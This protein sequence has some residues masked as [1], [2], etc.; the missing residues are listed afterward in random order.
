MSYYLIHAE[1]EADAALALP[2]LANLRPLVALSL[3]VFSVHR[4]RTPRQGD[5]GI[6]QRIY[7]CADQPCIFSWPMMI[8][9]SVNEFFVAV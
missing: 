3:V 6:M 8:S 5:H 4:F 7:N 1:L 9:N 2:A